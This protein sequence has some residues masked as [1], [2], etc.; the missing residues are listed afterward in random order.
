MKVDKT[1]W[2]NTTLE[3][4]CTHGSSDIV[5]SKTKIGNGN[6]KLYGASGYIGNIDFYHNDKPYL[7][8]IK[9]GSGVGRVDKYPAYSSLVGTMQYLYPSDNVDIDFLK[10]LIVHLN[11]AKYI[12]GAAIP[13]IYYRHYKNE[14]V[15]VPQSIT[16]QRAIATELDAVQKM[17]EGYKAQLA[18]L[19]TLAQSIFLD[20]FGDVVNNERKW[21]FVKFGSLTSSINYGTSA[22]AVDGGKY[23]YLR[24]GN[25]TDNGHLD[26]Q[27]I[28]YIDIPD[29]E[30]AKYIVHKGDILFNRT[31]S[32]EKV[33]KTACFMEEEEM[34][35]AGY[36]IRI[37]L[38]EEK[39][40]PLYIAQAFNTPEM[41]S[42][43]RRLARGSVGQANINSKEL[44]DIKISV[45]PLPLQQ[46][47]AERVEA[48]ERQKELL[49]AQLAEAQ[50]LMAERM[51]YYFD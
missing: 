29:N 44:S 16:E 37:R 4:L 18:D 45:P 19:D 9:D 47:F 10:Y 8:L 2:E 33:G 6:Y 36:I 25:I 12:K 20:M 28:K 50:T 51:Q 1:K 46:Q 26:F 7:G 39:S 21:N 11:L 30:I 42:Y 14:K 5:I 17:I 40:L 15:K 34:I 48:I 49:Q 35:I 31:N 13:H 22:P 27:D 3:K 38:N 23:K 43:L 24:M 32:R 41:K